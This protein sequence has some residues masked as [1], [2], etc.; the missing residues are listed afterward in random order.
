MASGGGETD[1]LDLSR[2]PRL[3]RQFHFLSQQTVTSARGSDNIRVDLRQRL[4]AATAA[5]IDEEGPLAVRVEKI[6]RRAGCSRATVYRYVADKDELVREVL[7]SR[8]AEIAA[9]LEA[10]IDEDGDP[11]DWIV[12]GLLA[13]AEAIRAEPWFQ[14][15]DRQGATAAIARV[16]GGPHAVAGL[17]A[18]IVAR[19][20]SRV[21]DRGAL[22]PTSL[23]RKRLNGSLT[24]TSHCSAR[25]L[26]TALQTN[27]PGRSTNSWLIRFSTIPRFQGLWLAEVVDGCK[28]SWALSSRL[29]QNLRPRCFPARRSRPAFAAAADSGLRLAIGRD[30][31]FRRPTVTRSHY[32]HHERIVDVAH[33]ARPQPNQGMT[34]RIKLTWPRSG[35]ARGGVSRIGGDPHLTHRGDI[36]WYLSPRQNPRS[37]R[38]CFGG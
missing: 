6:A 29:S 21:A 28:G 24:S 22:R 20:L 4:V 13:H 9:Q 38:N 5:V 12:N 16:G 8:S 30:S 35:P 23:L 1:L 3:L 2:R 14:A 33:A 27:V 32:V 25:S 19:F 26:P 37:I 18:P 11:A 10:E 7:V 34:Q 17:A 31:D 36:V 15:L